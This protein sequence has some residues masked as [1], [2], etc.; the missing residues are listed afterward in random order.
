VV[1]EPNIRLSTLKVGNYFLG[2]FT[3]TPSKFRINPPRKLTKGLI[4]EIDRAME[5][6][7]EQGDRISLETHIEA[8]DKVKRIYEDTRLPDSID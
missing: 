1:I 3:Y 5:K 6:W 4:H 7:H 2:T 8:R